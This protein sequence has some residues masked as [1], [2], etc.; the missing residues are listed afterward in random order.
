MEELKKLISEM[1]FIDEEEIKMES[2]LKDDLQIDSL[3][4]TNLI[5]DLEEKYN[6]KVENNELVALVTVADVVELLK[7]KGVEIE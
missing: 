2:R 1:F 6:I 7:N 4:A 5:L 3:A